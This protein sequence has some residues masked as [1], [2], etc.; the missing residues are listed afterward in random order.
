LFAFKSTGV[1]IKR[2]VECLLAMIQDNIGIA[3]MDGFAGS[4]WRYRNVYAVGYTTGRI[5]GSGLVHPGLNRT[6]GG[7]QAGTSRF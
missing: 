7:N 6:A 4:A 5:A 1:K 2:Q 3:V